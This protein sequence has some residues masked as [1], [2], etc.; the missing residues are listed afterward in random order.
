MKRFLYILLVV[1]VFIG[2]AF[3]EEDFTLH[4]GTKFGM[5]PDE[6]CGIEAD[7]GMDMYVDDDAWGRPVKYVYGKG[8]VAKQP[9]TSIT[10][11]FYGDNYTLYDM[12]YQFQTD[13]AYT[14]IE[15]MLIEKYGSTEYTSESGIRIPSLT[16]QIGQD[17]LESYY[18]TKEGPD[19]VEDEVINFSQRLLQVNDDII[20]IYH[21]RMKANTV[22]NYKVL[23]TSYSHGLRYVL[24][25]Q[26]QIDSISDF[27]VQSDDI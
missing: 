26:E 6:V 3:A 14:T 2:T 9:D 10:Y 1:I 18:R 11:A 8:M 17:I 15:S 5:T 13:D 23:S 24:L 21:Y 25:T 19:Y 12:W 16:N 4:N 20:L 7:H 22:M 27:F